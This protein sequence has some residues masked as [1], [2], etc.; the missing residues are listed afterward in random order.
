VTEMNACSA[1]SDY[2]LTQN[3]VP[4][5]HEIRHALRKL[6]DEGEATIID[7]RAM[8][9]APGEEDELEARL[10]AGEVSVRI[11]ALGPS[12]ITETSYPGVWLVVHYNNEE[13][14]MG[15]FVEI[16]RVP[17]IIESQTE[18]IESGIQALQESLTTDS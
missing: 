4:I 15:K 17:S 1:S 13:E 8:P 12:V 14:V 18:D 3:V 6:L 2:P 11:E 9:F 5:L 7:L 10:G 16:T